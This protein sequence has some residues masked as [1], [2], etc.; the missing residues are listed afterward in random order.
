MMA[1]YS[2]IS[3]M[4]YK[5]V[6]FSVSSNSLLLY[7]VYVDAEDSRHQRA[8]PPNEPPLWVPVP[9]AGGARRWVTPLRPSRR[10]TSVTLVFLES[11]LFVWAQV[12]IF[13]LTFFFY[14]YVMVC[15]SRGSDGAG[16]A[17]GRRGR[18]AGGHHANSEAALQV[19][20]MRLAFTRV[21][22]CV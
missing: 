4:L 15:S 19:P 20:S 8:K 21:D 13:D 3:L 22:V 17:L 10:S 14:R 1:V 6:N 7:K 12:G 2:L 9:V 11:G 16:G 5:L 18:A